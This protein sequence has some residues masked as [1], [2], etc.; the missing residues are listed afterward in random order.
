MDDVVVVVCLVVH[1]V[2]E[3]KAIAMCSAVRQ[4][5]SPLRYGPHVSVNPLLICVYVCHA[6]LSSP[7]SL[8]FLL[9]PHLRRQH[10]AQSSSS[11]IH[12][13]HQPQRLRLHLHLHLHLSIPPLG[14]LSTHPST[15]TLS[16]IQTVKSSP[17]AP[18]P[19]PP[20][21]NPPS[22]PPPQPPPP[23]PHSSTPPPTSPP[24]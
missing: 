12:S 2:I 6:I 3:W 21:L 13:I 20:P 5:S 14:R 15:R 18:P 23:S 7:L 10:A 19:P 8:F 9:P 16:I 17:L 11:M 1:V 24:S 22:V 4:V